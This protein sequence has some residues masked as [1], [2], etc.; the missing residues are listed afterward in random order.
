QPRP[1]FAACRDAADCAALLRDI[2]NGWYL[3]EQPALTQASGWVGAWDCAPSAYAVAVERPEDVVA[4]IAFARAHR[5]RLV[6]KGG[7]HGYQGTSNA[8]DSLLVWTRG[9]DRIELHEAFLPQGCA[10][11]VE[12]EPAVSVG[13]GQVWLPVHDAVTTGAGRYVQG[14]GCTTVGVAGLVQGGGFGS[15]S[16][17]FGLA[18]SGLLEAEMVTAD[19]ALRTVNAC[20]DPE[21]FWAIRGGGGG[22]FG[23]LT[24]L[25]LR[26]HP[27]PESFGAVSGS[28]RAGSD[29]AF[30]AMLGEILGFYRDALMNPAWGEQLVFGPGNRLRLFLVFQGMDAASAQ[31]IW[32]PFRDWLAAP[33]RDIAVEAP[34]GVMALPARHFWDAAFLRAAAPGLILPD[35][36]PG[37]PAGRFVWAGD[38]GQAGQML[39]AY[40]SAW[41]PASLLWDPAPLADAL[42]A[43]SRH[44]RVS[45]HLNKGLA[46]ASPEVVAEARGTPMNP[47][48]CE[49]FALAISAA[50]GPPAYP[51]QPGPSP[52]PARAGREA[53]AVGRA[54]DA[55]LA[56]A[57]GAGSYVSES[58]YFL[59]DWQRAHWGG[60][61][62]RLSEVKR[63]YDPE[64]L[65]IVHHGVGSE[66]WSEDGFTPRR[67]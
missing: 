10:G 24:R 65:F 21:L 27:L 57:P 31:A 56:V 34:L 18:A 26:T 60:N 48:V 49:A 30:R 58:D 66:D 20:Q 5:L 16:K 63:R 4:S 14:G 39:H 28:F 15:F 29:A 3:A 22:S 19:G 47:E 42:V 9:L 37:A 43:A 61:Y 36:R 52:D 35:D 55:L 11:R 59:P 41:L 13:A 33:G 45:L 54:M 62:P 46:G 12:P 8:P 6:V 25:T 51:G 7:G 67:T 32:A 1:P 23:V 64:G 44:W 2:R 38:A 40:R 53:A 50:S 17:R